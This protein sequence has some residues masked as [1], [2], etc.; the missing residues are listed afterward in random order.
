MAFSFK[1]DWRAIQWGATLQVLL[2]RSVAAGIVWGVVSMCMGVK[3]P[4]GFALPLLFPLIFV[5]MLLGMVL[6]G[7]VVSA[8]LGVIGLEAVGMFVFGCL[9]LIAMIFIIVGDPLVFFLRI[10]APRLVPVEKFNF[11]NFTAIMFVLDPA[12]IQSGN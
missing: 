11:L 8:V 6:L 9:S 12:R 7:K 1:Q 4:P 2:V 5:P 10:Q 3:D